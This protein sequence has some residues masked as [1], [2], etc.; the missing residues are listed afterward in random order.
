M[1]MMGV[2]RGIDEIDD[3]TLYL[4]M[5]ST[6][7]RTELIFPSLFVTDAGMHAGACECNRRQNQLAL[8]L[9]TH[10]WISMDAATACCFREWQAGALPSL[11]LP[12]AM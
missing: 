7:R 2:G 3:Q 6:Q 11:V 8:L 1:R 5:N 10:D 12:T 4:Y 9:A